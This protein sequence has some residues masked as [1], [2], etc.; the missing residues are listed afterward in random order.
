M[1][2]DFRG[3]LEAG[4][5]RAWLARLVA[6]ASLPFILVSAVVSAIGSTMP[7]LDAYTYL[8][9]G[10]RLNAD[11]ALYAL[12]TGDRV[13][14]TYRGNPLFSPPLIAVLW[15]PLA[16]LPDGSGRWLW[17]AA[18][19]VVILACLMWLLRSQRLGVSVAVFLLAMPIGFEMAVG[20]MNGFLAAGAI[21]VWVYRRE[22]WVGAIIG[23]MASLKVFP[24]IL[25]CWLVGQ[26][27]WRAVA[28]FVAAVGICAVAVVLGAGPS[29]LTDYASL[30]GQIPPSGRSLA[31]LT[32][33]SWAPYVLYG[34][35]ALLALASRNRAGLG[36]SAAVI[37]MTIGVPTFNLNWM[38]VLLAALAPVAT[39]AY[40]KP[41][42][43]GGDGAISALS[44]HS[45]G[46]TR[47]RVSSEIL[48]PPSVSAAHSRPQRVA[49][50][51][52]A[53]PR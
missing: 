32:G 21:L 52:G 36:F 39:A 29:S 50:A 25:V 16:A 22:W 43:N 35:A 26:R 42:E 28:A 23:V 45:T 1:R 15:R 38:V 46:T 44:K 18:Q 9:A 12:A 2:R 27:Q 7:A 47:R 4:G 6:I 24:V 31:A 40:A 33:I 19:I 13:I 30:V 53:P 5:R 41:L 11:H 17:T 20:N 51:L 34:A 14:A 8:A 49:H 48:P 10:E 37:G 3:R